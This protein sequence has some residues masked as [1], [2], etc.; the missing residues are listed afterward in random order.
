VFFEEWTNGEGWER[1][2]VLATECPRISPAFLAEERRSLPDWV[3][4]QEYLCSFEETEDAVFTTEMVDGAVSPDVKPLF[5]AN[6]P[7]GAA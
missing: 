1:Y 5:E 6:A 3:F 4:R 2:E 7:R